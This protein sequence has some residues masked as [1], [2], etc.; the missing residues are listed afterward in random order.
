MISRQPPRQRGAAS[1]AVVMVLFFILAMVAAYTNRNLVFEQRTSANSYKAARSL[2][3]ADAGVDWAIS[4]LNGGTIGPACTSAGATD[5]FRRRYFQFDQ[6]TVAGKFLHKTGATSV[7]TT[8]ACSARPGGGWDCSCPTGGRAVLS[9]AN[10]QEPVFTVGFNDNASN[11]TP[12]GVIDIRSRGCHSVRSGTVTAANVNAKGS[13]HIEDLF[14]TEMVDKLALNVDAVAM[15]RVSVGLVSALPVVPSAALTVDG[16][17][18]QSAGTQ[19]NAINPD[20]LTGLALRA[21]GAV[22]DPASVRTAGP[23]GSSAGTMVA[24]DSDLNTIPPADFFRRTLGI[25][26][27]NYRQQPAV[28]MLSCAGGCS[29]T[30][31]LV[32]A[33]AS[34]PTRTIFVKGDL[35]LDTAAAIGSASTPTMLVVTGNVNISQAVTFNGVIFAG[36]NVTWAASGGV[37]NGALI[38]GGDYTG[39]GNA[40]IAYDRAIVQKIHKGYGSFVRIPG[41]WITEG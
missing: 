41:S 34:A 16:L 11:K 1:L 8:P 23:A 15:V 13:C 14:Q 40:A 21:G 28:T 35:D 29:A 12:P 18:N 6:V 3:A 20:P 17:V 39:T 9:A 10:D 30:A 31:T 24:N 19:L 26:S 22:G 38:A 25:P 2:A 4:M 36:G 5:D 37:V 7:Q 33:L 32:P 27:D